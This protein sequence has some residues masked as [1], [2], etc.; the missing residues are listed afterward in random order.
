VETLRPRLARSS[1]MPSRPTPDRPEARLTKVLTCTEGNTPVRMHTQGADFFP[2]THILQRGSTD[3]KRGVATQAFLRCSAAAPE[4][5]PNQPVVVAASGRRQVLGP[6]ADAVPVDDRHR[7]R[8]RAPAGA[9]DREPALAASLRSWAG[10]HP[11]RLRRPGIAS[12]PSR[13]ARLA[14]RRTDPPGM[15]AQTPSTSCC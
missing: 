8:C 4:T 14:R 15:A 12:H 5:P 13:T 11:E 10:G 1:P 7:A 6:P 9:G 3:Q 2:E